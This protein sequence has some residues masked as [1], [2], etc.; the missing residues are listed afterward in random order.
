M[1][2]TAS[3][4]A[5]MGSTR[6]PGKVLKDI[7]GKPM[8]LWQVERIQ[9]SRLVDEVV[10]AT[11]TCSKDDEIIEFCEKYE[12]NYFRGSEDDVLN[13]IASLISKK[14]I[15][16]HVEFYGDSPFP[17]PQLIDEFIGYYLKHHYKYDYV[18]NSMVT[19]YPPGQEVVLYRG[20]ILIEIDELLSK[21]DL[22]R[23]HVAYNITR[24][25]HKYRLASLEAPEW[26]HQPEA[27]LEVDTAKDLQM[28]RQLAGY[29]VKRGQ[30]HFTLS[31]ILDLL[32]LK[33]E[34]M[35]INSQEERRWKELRKQ[36]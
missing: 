18:S 14:K 29:F 4:Q 6:L 12:I 23:E 7:C 26:Y 28:M 24:F 19:T 11:T 35:D 8:L 34:I 9:R 36:N 20:D 25:P 33:P 16:L 32:K 10:V 3:I 2:I 27:Y 13:R 1:N 30:G 15:D 5:R 17:D 22:L 21:D 31:Q